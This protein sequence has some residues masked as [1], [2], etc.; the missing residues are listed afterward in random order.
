MENIESVL[1]PNQPAGGVDRWDEF[2]NFVGSAV[3]IF[4]PKAEH[5]SPVFVAAQRA[6]SIAGNIEVA[7]WRCGNID[8]VVG[9]LPGSVEG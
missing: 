4:I 2:G 6:T 8:R 7:R 5:P 9:S 1:I 3:S